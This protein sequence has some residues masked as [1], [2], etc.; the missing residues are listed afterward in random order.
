MAY[1]G[2]KSPSSFYV[3]RDG[4]AATPPAGK[5]FVAVTPMTSDNITVI[6]DQNSEG[7]FELNDGGTA[8]ET[9]GS[10][11]VVIDALPGVTIYGTFNSVSIAAPGFAIAYVG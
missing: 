10:D 2:A 11:G 5:R 8:Y 4:V 6:A 7:L 9:A 1:P 3:V